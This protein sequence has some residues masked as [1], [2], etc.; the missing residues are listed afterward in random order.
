MYIL[1]S[2]FQ[3]CFNEPFKSNNKANTAIAENMPPPKQFYVL[4]NAFSAGDYIKKSLSLIF[5]FLVD[6]YTES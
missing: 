3:K 6:N 2:N 5:K 1:I 4:S